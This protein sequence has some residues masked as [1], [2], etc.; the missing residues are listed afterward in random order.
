MKVLVVDDHEIVRR[1]LVAM[2]EGEVGFDSIQEAKNMEEAKRLLTT[3]QPDIT[4]VDVNLGGKNGLDL[5]ADIGGKSSFTKFV[6][7]TSSSRKGD[8][9]RAKELN[10]DGYIL[11]DSNIEDII[12]AIKSISRGRKFYDVQITEEKETSERSKVLDSLTGR[13]TEIFEEI[14]RGL[15]NGQIAQKLY[16]TEN[17]VKKHTSSLLSKLEVKRRTEIAL[18]ATKLWRRKGEL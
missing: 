2:L 16:I 1:G 8:F 18:Y 10:V 15:T 3:E 7:F 17:T 11:K 12:Y 9:I 6:V 14:G 13:E 4:I 5:I